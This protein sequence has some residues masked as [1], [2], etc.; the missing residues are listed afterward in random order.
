MAACLHRPEVLILDEPISGVDPA[1]RDLFWQRLAS[2]SRQEGVT[3]FVSTHFMNEAA[4]CDRIS[5][6]YWGRV[7]VVGAPQALADARGGGDL[8][9]AFIAWLQD[10]AREDGQASAEDGE[11]A[12]GALEV[13]P[14]ALPAAPPA[15][16][17]ATPAPP[18]PRSALAR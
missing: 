11:G 18:A 6:M 17:A 3:I 2:L 10:A 9:R 13:L 12:E 8:E 14:A 15:P 5:L 16:E 1:A 7:L 4:R